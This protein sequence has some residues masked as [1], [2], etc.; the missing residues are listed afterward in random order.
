M[1]E[2]T[3]SKYRDRRPGQ[4]RITS[5]LCIGISW[6]LIFALLNIYFPLIANI[7]VIKRKIMVYQMNS[8][9]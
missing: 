9:P 8:L 2:R 4:I 5:P 1:V 3:S 6:V 7:F